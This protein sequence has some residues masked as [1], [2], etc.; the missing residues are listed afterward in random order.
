MK[1]IVN[2][3]SA[4]SPTVEPAAAYYKDASFSTG[5]TLSGK[6]TLIYTDAPDI[7]SLEGGPL[8]KYASYLLLYTNLNEIT[9]TLLYCGI[10]NC[11]VQRS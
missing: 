10:C 3:L 9:L 2:D 5:S 11:Q 4:I 6:W 8:S 1:Q 7:T